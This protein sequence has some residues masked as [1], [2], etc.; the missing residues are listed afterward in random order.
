[1]RTFKPTITKFARTIQRYYILTKPGIIRGNTLVAAAGFFL[2]AQGDV[3]YSRLAGL[4]IGSAAIIA[5][6]CVVNN[7]IDRDID[8]YMTRTK[9]RA[10]VTGEIRV[11][12]ALIYASI[13][14]SIGC[15]ILIQT[16]YILT[17]ILGLI[18]F[19]AYTAIY[20]P[21]KRRTI[22]STLIGSVSGA[23][24]P[25]AGYSAAFG[26]IDLGGIILFIILVCWQMPHF[27]AIAVYRHAEYKAATVPTLSVARGL[28]RTRI[29]IIIYT[30][31]F[32]AASAWLYLSGYAGL[33]YASSM[34]AA[35][36][37]WLYFVLRGMK[38]DVEP[39]RWGRQVFGVSLITILVLS[40]SI[41]VDSF[42]KLS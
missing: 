23:I 18:G 22:H 20:T 11:S 15:A 38:S 3:D 31:L 42:V 30:L 1:M 35:C 13:L 9:S 40:V 41:T 25:L 24:P 19:I 17:L 5:A 10:L 2:A 34:T 36:V 6:A 37:V 8:Q 29:E 21:A 33:I 28:R 26:H 7:C 14:L 39:N 12:A 27:Y 32:T 16:T 4:L